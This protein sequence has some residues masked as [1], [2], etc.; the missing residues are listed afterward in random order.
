M[1]DSFRRGIKVSKIAEGVGF[2][3]QTVYKYLRNMSDYEECKRTVDYDLAE[4]TPKILRDYKNGLSFEGIRNKYGVALSIKNTTII[5][6][7]NTYKLDELY[8]NIPNGKYKEID[9]LV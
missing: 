4:I 3:I 6:C 7:M 8:E 9:K 2:E 1:Q 5:I